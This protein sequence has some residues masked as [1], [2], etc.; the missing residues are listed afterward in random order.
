[1][2]DRKWDPLEK[3]GGKLR[4]ELIRSFI[5]IQLLSQIHCQMRLSH[6]LT[7]QNTLRLENKI[8]T[9]QKLNV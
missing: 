7:E 5:Y 6:A 9:D 1:M 2:A 4:L 3:V 8:Q